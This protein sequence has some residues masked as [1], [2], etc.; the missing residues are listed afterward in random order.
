M[1]AMASAASETVR[2]VPPKA[3][4]KLTRAGRVHRSGT[5]AESMRVAPNA[6]TISAASNAITGRSETDHPMPTAKAT[7]TTARVP[8]PM[9]LRICQPAGV[10]G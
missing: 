1:N 5:T 7:P 6:N 10:M 2:S 9:T 8:R 4:R 3:I